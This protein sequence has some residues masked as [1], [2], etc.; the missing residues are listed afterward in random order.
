MNCNDVSN[1]WSTWSSK[2]CNKI[3]NSSCVDGE[4]VDCKIAEIFRKKFCESASYSSLSNLGLDC[5]NLS[6]DSI[7]SYLFRVLEVDSIINKHMKRG[8]AAG[9]DNITLEHV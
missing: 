2:T 4:V 5:G 7:H 1:F 8:K 6:T 3:S 9:I